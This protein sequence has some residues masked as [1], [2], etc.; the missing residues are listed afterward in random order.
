MIVP[1]LIPLFF[2]WVIVQTF[3]VRSW[4]TESKP[5]TAHLQTFDRSVVF[6]ESAN[7]FGGDE[8]GGNEPETPLR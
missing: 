4:L 2:L 6:P 1:E 7:D 3:I 5:T 8:T